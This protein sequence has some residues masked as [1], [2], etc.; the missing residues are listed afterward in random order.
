[1]TSFSALLQNSSF[2]KLTDVIGALHNS[3]PGEMLARE[4]E[5][6]AITS[7]IVTNAKDH[8]AKSLYIS[9]APG[10]GKTALTT[11]ISRRPEV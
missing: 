5:R 3:I 8:E 4:E 6:T 9:G 7:F 2:Y 10:T 11:S 1:M